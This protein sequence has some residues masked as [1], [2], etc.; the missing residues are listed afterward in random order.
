MTNEHIDSSTLIDYLHHELAPG[1]DVLVHA[2]LTACTECAGAYEAE[3][4]LTEA[5]RAE[6]R[7]AERELPLR[8]EDHILTGIADRPIPA[9]FQRLHILVRPAI[10]LPAA[11]VLV[12]ALALGFASLDSHTQHAP[13]IAAAYYLDAH[14]A[15]SNRSLPFAQTSVVPAALDN[16]TTNAGNASAAI[17]ANTIAS[18]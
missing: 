11:A 16:G 17:A 10:G 15:L 9:W 6:A 14:A 3:A 13:T 2:H 7:A 5:L 1:Q 8:V 12:L 18:E 4:R